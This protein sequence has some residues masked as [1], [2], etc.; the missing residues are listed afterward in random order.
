MAVL[1]I[2]A[3]PNPF[4]RKVAQKVTQ[5]DDALKQIVADMSETMVKSDGLGLAATQVG[6]DMQL[7]ILSPLALKE[8]DEDLL[9]GEVDLVLINPEIVEQSKEEYL[10]SEGCLSFPDVYI[11][12]SRPLWVVVKALD[13][14]GKPFEIR[15]EKLGSRAMLHEMD[16]LSGKVM[17]DHVSF[18][19]RQKALNKH[20]KVQ[21]ILA[22][23]KAKGAGGKKK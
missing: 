17:I 22:E 4:L 2:L 7:F 11:N 8:K 9:P 3:Y 6:L 23:Q 14:N 12:V 20:Q 19:N 5:F 10:S 18:F 1:E 15:G 16:H 13:I 21:K